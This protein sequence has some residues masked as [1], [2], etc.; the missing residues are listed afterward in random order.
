MIIK[1]LFIANRGEI[2]VRAARACEKRKIKAVI[3]YSFSDSH[4]LAT[5]YADRNI[6]YGWELAV[7]GGTSAEETYANPKKMLEAA[8]LHKCD[9]VFLGYGFLAE[10]HEFVRMCK[11]AGLKV[12]APP[13]EIMES[14][15]NK[16][17]ARE[18]AKK[19]KIGAF[20][21][22]PVLEGTG[23]LESFEEAVKSAKDLGYPVMLKDPD[24][25]GG[26]GNIVA[27]NETELQQAYTT[28]KMNRNNK[29][30]FMERFIKRAVHVEVQI[31]ADT[32]G[33]V[34]HLGDRDCT[35]QR[36]SQK[37]IEESPSP[38]IPQGLREV[39]LT[40]AVSFAKNVGYQGAGT[41]E[42][43]IDLDRKGRHGPAWYFMEVNPRIQVEHGVTEQQTGIDIVN[44]MIDIAEGKKL[45]FTQEQIKPEGVTMEVRVYAEKPEEG[46]KQTFGNLQVLKYPSIKG[47]R[48]DKGCEQGDDIS[49]WFDPTIC[50]LLSHAP[51]REEARQKLE[52]ALQNLDIVGVQ[53]NRDFLIE[54]LNTEEFK[55]AYGTTTFVESWWQKQLQGKIYAWGGIVKK[56]TFTVFSGPRAFNPQLLPQQIKV[57]SR[58]SSELISYSQYYGMQE[59]KSGQK[60]A[61]EFGIIDR[62]GI[63]FVLYELDDRFAAGT[64]GVAEGIVFEE[65]CK[66][67]NA[68]NLPLV[69]ISRSGGARQHENTLALFQMGA[70]VHALN[71]YPPLFHINIYSGGVYGGVPASF[72]GVADIQIAVNA[73][74]TKIGFTGPYITAR[75]LGKQPKS[76]SAVDSYAEL[77][78]GTHSPLHAFQTRNIDILASSLEAASDKITHLLHI[79]K[80]P[81]TVTDINRVFAVYEHIGFAQMQGTA[82]RFDRPGIGVFAWL[83]DKIG[84]LFSKHKKSNGNGKAS[85]QF[86]P[87]LTIAQKKKAL[88][89]VNRP[90]AAD[91][92][93]KGAGIFDDA[94]A[95]TSVLQVEGAEQYPPV[96]AAVAKLNNDTVMVLAHQTQ[97]VNDEK[98]KHR[99]KVYD[100]QKPADWE[101]T[102]RMIAYAERMHLPIVLIGDTL[103]ADCLPDSEDRNQSHKIAR[104]LK[105]L[106]IYPYP[107]LSV[108]IGF[109]GSG[110]G[111]TFIRPFDSAADFENSLSYVSDPM[112]QYWIL[113]GKWID[114]TSSVEAQQELAKFIEQLTDSTAQSRLETHQIDYIIREGKGGAHNDPTIAA[115]N[116]RHW[117]KKQLSNLEKYSSEELLDRRHER[118]ERVNNTVTV[119][120]KN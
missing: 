62:D 84:S 23:N 2:A 55:N 105:L 49:P 111:E 81:S 30:L 27:N 47:L 68:K 13:A 117:L 38:Q 113:T 74:E 36:R 56:G 20:S 76:F 104:I 32:Q 4:S 75:T 91:L 48:I 5:R 15:G 69:T 40:T 114:K 28:L 97:R 41:W 109:K 16:V 34:V 88:M 79:L 59:E 51:T 107:V 29:S 80:I 9:A 3:P 82:N 95:L 94:I 90:S 57:P 72:A 39:I 100:P 86:Y 24:T 83:R 53:N 18:I 8:L 92:I 21:T 77:P 119:G 52:S 70:A 43:I 115:S 85:S 61:A 25:G 99:L 118:I 50:K 54:L 116:L 6:D 106:D 120:T 67:A 98:S 12:L 101:Y 42:F 110:G 22:I 17:T 33:N 19:I 103:G 93:D 89:H 35:M 66:L 7:L 64:L 63:Q 10:N 112:V 37:I 31:L 11:K 108:N 96:I 45:A 46:F 73:K 87:P 65:A 60:S 14:V 102:E 26:A 71:K 44:T 58:K 1:K 78:E